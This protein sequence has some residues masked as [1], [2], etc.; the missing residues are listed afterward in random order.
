[1]HRLEKSSWLCDAH[2]ARQHK[3]STLSSFPGSV[4]V[5][6]LQALVQFPE[7]GSAH[8]AKTALEGH[9]IY[10]GGF[11]R[12]PSTYLV[13]TYSAPM[14][15]PAIDIHIAVLVL[16]S[17]C[18][19]RVQL[20]IAYSVHQDLNVKANN[21]KSWDYIG[22]TPGGASIG[23]GGQMAGQPSGGSHAGPHSDEPPTGGPAR[24][25]KSTNSARIPNMPGGMNQP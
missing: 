10:D 20:K 24:Q 5:Q 21:D 18:V 14:F 19:A 13:M 8:N 6:L 12:V 23:G 11:N 25:L 2:L 3:L 22:L 17:L 7:A 1:M 9:A 15:L 16:S 4:R